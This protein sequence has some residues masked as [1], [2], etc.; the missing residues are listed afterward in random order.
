MRTFPRNKIRHAMLAL[1][2]AVATATAL[3]SSPVR[4]DA[5]DWRWRHDRHERHEWRGHEWREHHWNYGWG[6][7]EPPPA[8]VYGPGPG[9][10]FDVHIR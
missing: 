1:G 7:V 8:V 10:N 5:D 4:A 9:V 6:Y 2:F 3:A